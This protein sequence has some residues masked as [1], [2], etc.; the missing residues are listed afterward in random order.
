MTH[1]RLTLY[2]ELYKLYNNIINECVIILSRF[3]I[4]YSSSWS[5]IGKKL[6][7][8]SNK[9]KYVYINNKRERNLLIGDRLLV[10]S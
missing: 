1:V 2:A 8:K 7:K 10:F 4:L 9:N 5:A 6:K 3:I